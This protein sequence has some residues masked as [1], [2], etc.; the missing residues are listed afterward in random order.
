MQNLSKLLGL[1][2]I[3][4]LTSCSA[5]QETK[6]VVRT[7]VKREVPPAEW[8]V[9]PQKPVKNYRTNGELYR[10]SEK[11]EAAFDTMVESL[12][13]IGVWSREAKNREEQVQPPEK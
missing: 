1:V 9:I 11:L 13:K 8:L 4:F 5:H 6:V 7:E 3:V 10:Y 2:L 12:T